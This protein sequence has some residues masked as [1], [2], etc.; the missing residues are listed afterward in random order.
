MK[1]GQ[2]QGIRRLGRSKYPV[3]SK[4]SSQSGKQ[5]FSRIFCVSFSKYVRGKTVCFFFCLCCFLWVRLP[6]PPANLL[7]FA[8]PWASTILL[9]LL[10]PFFFVSSTSAFSL[11][12]AMAH[13][14]LSSR[15]VYSLH[16]QLYIEDIQDNAQPT[17]TPDEW[18][19]LF[20][21]DMN[22][23]RTIAAQQQ[24]LLWE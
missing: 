8:T 3:S 11:H 6:P 5:V 1:N 24:N 20:M 12:F 4:R 9:F 2:L 17:I 16:G 18:H 15:S 22:F 10:V 19:M 23:N 13:N 21:A 7:V 14:D